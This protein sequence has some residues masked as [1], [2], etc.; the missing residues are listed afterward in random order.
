M[1]VTGRPNVMS[2]MRKQHGSMNAAPRV[3]H[4]QSMNHVRPGAMRTLSGLKSACSRWP[5]SS[6]AAS[7]GSSRQLTHRCVA[8][9]TG[10]SGQGMRPSSFHDLYDS[11]QVGGAGA[12]VGVPRVIDV[13]EGQQ[14]PPRRLGMP[15]QQR[16]NWRHVR[17]DHRFRRIGPRQPS[18]VVPSGRSRP[19]RYCLCRAGRRGRTWLSP[20]IS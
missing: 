9:L 15:Q 19:C 18:P 14:V 1:T 12:V 17:I 6:S 2:R 3:G 16:S 20:T 13:V 11:R 8:C 10:R 5:P 7:A 4:A